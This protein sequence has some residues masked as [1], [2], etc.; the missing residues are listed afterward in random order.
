MRR[1][2]LLGAVVCLVLVMAVPSLAATAQ[3]V[4][5][6]GGTAGTYYPLGGAMSQI[7]NSRVK[8]VNVSVQS[9]GASVANIRMIQNGEVDL[10]LVQTDI[11]DYAWNGTEMFKDDG[12]LQ[13]F[14]VIASLYPELIQVVV[15]AESGIES[16]ADLKGKKVSVGAPGS[17]TEAN[18]RQILE[19][20]GLTYKDLAQVQYLSFSESA[21]AFKDKHIDAFFVTAGIPNAGIQDTATMHKIQILA[22]PDDMYKNLHNKY[23]FYGQALIPAGCYINQT[24]PVRTVAVQAVLIARRDLDADVVYEMTAALFENLPELATAH[25]KGKEVSLEGALTGVSTPLHPGA[26]KYFKEKGIVK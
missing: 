2:L 8:D 13:N 26:E 5:A 16:I 25:A 11:A 1:L 14:S 17:G 12:K 21:E 19:I 10:A 15:R 20:Y 6:T 7:I 3:L 24:E 22:V 9:T 4:M 18:A 23:G